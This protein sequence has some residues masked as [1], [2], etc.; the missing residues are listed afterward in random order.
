[1]R[2]QAP[3]NRIARTKEEAKFSYDRMSGFYDLLAGRSERRYKEKGLEI[4]NV[5]GGEVVLEIGFG[6][7]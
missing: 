1:M 5:R 2:N 4:L 3:I 7:G 6:T